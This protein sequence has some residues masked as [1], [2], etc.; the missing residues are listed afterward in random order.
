MISQKAFKIQK[1]VIDNLTS[2][3]GSIKT[4]NKTMRELID[5]RIQVRG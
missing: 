4:I 2:K 3:T 5:N 1:S